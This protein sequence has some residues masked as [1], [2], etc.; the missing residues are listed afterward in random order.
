MYEPGSEWDR[1]KS[2][3]QGKLASMEEREHGGSGIDDEYEPAPKRVKQEPDSAAGSSTQLAGGQSVT[4]SLSGNIGS[5][6]LLQHSAVK[7]I[8]PVTQAAKQLVSFYDFVVDKTSAQIEAGAVELR[9][10]SFNLGDISLVLGGNDVIHWDWIINF[11]MSMKD[12]TNLGNTFQYASSVKSDLQQNTIKAEI[13]LG[14]L[15][16]G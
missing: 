7:S 5:D 16:A 2:L 8:L 15:G 11:A 10:M 12:S 6:W 13:L 4:Q 3:P 1:E 14:G 9:S